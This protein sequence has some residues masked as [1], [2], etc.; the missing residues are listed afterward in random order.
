M[1]RD[2]GETIAQVGLS[3]AASVVT[4]PL[5][6]FGVL[7]WKRPNKT[8]SY[9]LFKAEL[10]LCRPCLEWA[11]R[12]RHGMELKDEAYRLHP[13]AELARGIGYDTYLSAY[14]IESLKP[15]R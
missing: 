9:S 15:A 13:W 14:E 6:G 2:W 11:W 3:A 10:V 8:A 5:T 7:S 12:T 4:A 1:K